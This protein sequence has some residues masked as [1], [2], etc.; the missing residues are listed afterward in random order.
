HR[1]FIPNKILL[2]AD[3]EAGQKRISGPMEWLN[4]LGPINGKATA[5][6]CENNV[7]R[8]PASDPAELA[9]I[10]DQQAIER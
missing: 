5:Y 2:L 9:A 1:R 4:R 7:C 8:L 3:G 10:L 6:L